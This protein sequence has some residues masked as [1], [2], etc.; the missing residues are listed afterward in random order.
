M[1]LFDWYGQIFKQFRN[2]TGYAMD[3][4]INNIYFKLTMQ[5]VKLNLPK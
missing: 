3:G 5:G 2:L 4:K 1:R